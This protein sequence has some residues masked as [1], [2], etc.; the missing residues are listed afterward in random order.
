[1][2]HTKDGKK[3]Y[4]IKTSIPPHFVLLTERADKDLKITGRNKLMSDREKFNLNFFDFPHTESTLRSKANLFIETFQDVDLRNFQLRDAYFKLRNRAIPS[5][6]KIQRCWRRYN[7]LKKVYATSRLRK[8]QTLQ[9]RNYEKRMEEERTQREL[10][11]KKLEAEQK[12]LQEKRR[13]EKEEIERIKKKEAEFFPVKSKK[14]A[15]TKYWYKIVGSKFK[16]TKGKHAGEK[17]IVK[18]R[19]LTGKLYSKRILT[20]DD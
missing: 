7:F 16:I 18:K 12:A 15:E 5:C 4:N 14:D 17:Y 6:K 20:D 19:R 10:E 3:Q 8:L 11:R 9:R 13:K 1:M 2:I